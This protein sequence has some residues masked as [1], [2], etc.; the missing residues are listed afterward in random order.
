MSDLA[1]EFPLYQGLHSKPVT[2]VILVKSARVATIL[3]TTPNCTVPAS[4]IPAAL[5]PHANGILTHS[6]HK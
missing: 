2:P 5:Q 6:M 1:A 3:A 4:V